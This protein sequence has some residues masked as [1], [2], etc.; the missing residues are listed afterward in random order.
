M[1]N[2]VA[3]YLL[4]GLGFCGLVFSLARTYYLVWKSKKERQEGGPRPR[5]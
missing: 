4:Y 5:R 2:H 1:S 3:A